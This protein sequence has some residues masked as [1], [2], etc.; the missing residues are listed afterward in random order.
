MVR[1]SRLFLAS[2]QT[3]L[4]VTGAAKLASSL[5]NSTILKQIDPVFGAS[6]GHLMFVSGI[7]EILG[8]GAIRVLRPMWTRY[9]LV[10]WFAAGFLCYRLLLWLGDYGKPC[11]CLG[12]LTDTL[13]I[14]ARVVDQ[15]LG[16]TSVYLLAGSIFLAV[17]PSSKQETLADVGSGR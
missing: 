14:D 9:V 3:I 1:A 13:G 2:A 6:Y 12:T 5:G 17:L 15:V 4:F 16:I 7:I 10:F 11:P 8:C